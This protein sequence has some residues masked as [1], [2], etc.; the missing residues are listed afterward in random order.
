MTFNY[1]VEIILQTDHQPLAYLDKAK[2]ENDT[3]MRWAMYLQSYRFTVQD[4][5]GLENVRANFLSR[6]C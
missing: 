5:K 1:G 3:I 6:M 2:F 4:I